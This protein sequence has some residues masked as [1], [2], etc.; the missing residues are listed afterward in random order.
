MVEDDD[1]TLRV[2]DKHHN[3]IVFDSAEKLLDAIFLDMEYLNKIKKMT[4]QRAIKMKKRLELCDYGTDGYA[5]SLDTK[6]YDL[7]NLLDIY[8]GDDTFISDNDVKLYLDLY[9]VANEINKYLALS[10]S[11]FSMNAE[12]LAY[13]EYQDDRKIDDKQ[14]FMEIKVLNCNVYK[15]FYYHYLDRF[16]YGEYIMLPNRCS[17]YHEL[18]FKAYAR[19]VED[20][21]NRLNYE[22]KEEMFEVKEIFS[23]DDYEFKPNEASEHINPFRRKAVIHGDGLQLSG[24]SLSTSSLN[25]FR[26]HS[27][28]V[29]RRNED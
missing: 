2:R 22:V 11:V 20:I 28:K 17:R 4:L 6:K 29:K 1:N 16:D 23:D 10:K 3:L 14:Y 26:K 7:L 15:Y 9:L 24:E 13:C 18:R 5:I 25:S 12:M 27:T 21:L 8:D 19:S